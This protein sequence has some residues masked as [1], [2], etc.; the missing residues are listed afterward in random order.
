MTDHSL[1]DIS[2]P[3]FGRLLISF[4]FWGWALWKIFAPDPAILSP[5]EKGYSGAIRYDLLAFMVVEILGGLMLLLGWKTR[6][7]CVLLMVYLVPVTFFLHA[8]WVYHGHEQTMHALEFVNDIAI[9]G[10]LILLLA[11][12]PGKWSYDELSRRKHNAKK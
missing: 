5:F 8:F 2:A 1:R 6:F 12:G 9:Y 4:N 3:F 11:T 7:A 10:A